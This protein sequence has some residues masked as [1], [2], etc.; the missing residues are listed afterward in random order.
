MKSE[1]FYKNP[2]TILNKGPGYLF[3][4]ESFPLPLY[5]MFIRLFVLLCKP[6]ASITLSEYR[7]GKW[8]DMKNG[9][10]N[11]LSKELTRAK[12]KGKVLIFMSSSTDPYQPI[13]Q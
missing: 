8:V 6:N 10:A 7:V 11:I 12:T 3:R 5:R 4:L 1:L 9:A 2:K 13:E